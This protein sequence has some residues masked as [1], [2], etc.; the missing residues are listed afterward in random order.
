MDV[1]IQ[2]IIS[3]SRRTAGAGDDLPSN[4]QVVKADGLAIGV[5]RSE[6]LTD[7]SSPGF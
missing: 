6:G 7:N 1:R 4:E 2:E 5:R 3:C